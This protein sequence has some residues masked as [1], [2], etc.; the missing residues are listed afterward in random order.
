MTNGTHYI[1][2]LAEIECKVTITGGY[3][4]NPTTGQIT[5]FEAQQQF[6]AFIHFEP[7]FKDYYVTIS[8]LGSSRVSGLFPTHYPQTGMVISSFQFQGEFSVSYSTYDDTK[9]KILNGL[10]GTYKATGTS[11]ISLLAP[12][13]NSTPPEGH[14]HSRGRYADLWTVFLTLTRRRK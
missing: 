2:Q 4:R 14:Y 11:S 12:I 7:E 9:A 10:T 1:T 5:E 13:S 3:D 6:D 8:G